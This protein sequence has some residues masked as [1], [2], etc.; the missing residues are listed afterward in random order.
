M[1]TYNPN[2]PNRPVVSDTGAAAGWGLWWLFWLFLIIIFF[3]GGWGWGGWWWGG[4]WWGGR[5]TNEPRQQVQPQASVNR[6]VENAAPAELVDRTATI[7]GKV[8]KVL[9]KDAFTIASPAPTG[10]DLLV[11]LSRKAK[12]HPEIKGGEQVK[13]TGKIETFNQ[14]DFRKK[15]E[16]NLPEDKVAAFAGHSALLASAVEESGANTS[17]PK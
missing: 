2:D 11:V 13:V 17:A 8:D 6:T 15:S 4:P 7:T 16:A 12:N 9:G 14:A 10:R 5:R 1:A 3:F